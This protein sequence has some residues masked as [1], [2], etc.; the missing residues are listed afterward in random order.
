MEPLR[1]EKE[2]ETNTNHK[3][4]STEARA[5]NRHFHAMKFYYGWIS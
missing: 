3:P 5:T 4:I 1:H 2:M